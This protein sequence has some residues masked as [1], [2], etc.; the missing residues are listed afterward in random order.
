M[1]TWKTIQPDLTRTIMPPVEETPAA[2]AFTTTGTG[3]VVVLLHA[4][5]LDQSIFQ[6]QAQALAS[7]GF[8]VITPNYAGHGDAERVCAPATVEAMA[9]QVFAGLDVLG[10]REQVVLGGLSMGGYVSFAAWAKYRKRIRGLILMDTRALPDTPE[11]A[12]NRYRASDLIR[13]AGSVGPLA[14]T[15]M[16]RLLGK[17]TIGHKPHVW[18]Q[19][20]RVI[21]QT[22]VEA[23]CD[24]LAALATRPDRRAMLS[25][26][27]VPT[28]VLTG[29]EDII[30]TPAEM[31]TIADGITAARFEV[32]PQAGHLVTVETPE[33][34]SQQI[35]SFL[36]NNL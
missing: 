10:V 9:D 24:A 17:T 18:G 23:A 33:V 25:S 16:L 11:E 30:S 5:L 13:Q 36:M 31:K 14:A 32:I 3:P 27:N 20:A 28:L 12:A 6:H 22:P 35:L 7:Q 34:A 26:I 19:V 29:E 1:V 15:M 4:L 21:D 8:R 2:P